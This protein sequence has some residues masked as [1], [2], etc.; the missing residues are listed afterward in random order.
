MNP[1]QA[2]GDAVEKVTDAIVGAAKSARDAL[3]GDSSRQ[4]VTEA[5][6]EAVDTAK[7]EVKSAI[8]QAKKK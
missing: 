6:K 1:G 5:V 4:D 2:A 7:G 3:R 8:E